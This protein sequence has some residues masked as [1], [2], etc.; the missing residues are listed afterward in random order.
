MVFDPYVTAFAFLGGACA[1]G[2]H[3]GGTLFT[4]VE[5]DGCCTSASG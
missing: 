1:H 2:I 5:M 4:I 3:E